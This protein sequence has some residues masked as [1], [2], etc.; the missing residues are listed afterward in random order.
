LENCPQFPKIVELLLDDVLGREE[1][2]V[3]E[4]A[5][6]LQEVA[7]LLLGFE[8]LYVGDWLY[9]EQLDGGLDGYFDGSELGDFTC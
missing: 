4:S 1:L 5:V 6:T 9:G 8:D 2:D 7:G 3:V